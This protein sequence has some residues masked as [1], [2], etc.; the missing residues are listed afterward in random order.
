MSA[1]LHTITA[2]PQGVG[3]VELLE[4][5]LVQAKEGKLSSIAVA[6]ID[7]E[8]CSDVGWSRAPSGM[9]LV[10]AISRLLYRYNVRLDA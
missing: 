3:I 8:G 7:R 1:Q 2:E 10:G 6:A 5:Y 4:E 9:L